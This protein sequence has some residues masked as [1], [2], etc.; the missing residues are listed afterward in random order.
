MPRK[1][2]TRLHDM[3]PT[4]H[5]YAELEMIE[6]R[7][8]VLWGVNHYMDGGSRVDINSRHAITFAIMTNCTV[9]KP[10]RVAFTLKQRGQKKLIMISAPH[11]VPLEKPRN[12]DGTMH[13]FVLSLPLKTGIPAVPFTVV[14]GGYDIEASLV[15]QQGDDLG[16]GAVVSG[17]TV[18][19]Y[20]PT[21]HFV[22][23]TLFYGATPPPAPAP[24]TPPRPIIGITQALRAESAS[25]IPDYYPIAPFSLPTVRER[26]WLVSW[27]AIKN[28]D[29]WDA[30]RYVTGYVLSGFDQTQADIFA[31][32]PV[33][34]RFMTA[35]SNAQ[36]FAAF[37]NGANRMVIVMGQYDYD[38][39]MGSS[40]IASYNL[41]NKAVLMRSGV[42]AD[43]V[44]HEVAHTLPPP[45]WNPDPTCNFPYHNSGITGVVADP[46]GAGTTANGYAAGERLRLNGA[47]RRVFTD[48][49]L[50]L[51][52]GAV[53]V[54]TKRVYAYTTQCTYWHLTDAMLAPPD[55]PVFLVRGV[56]ARQGSRFAALL[57]P[58]YT[59]TGSADLK[60]DARG[61][62]RITLLDASGKTLGSYAFTPD[63]NDENGKPRN[64]VPF[65]YR[66]PQLPGANAIVLEGEGRRIV[67]R[68]SSAAPAVRILA[69]RGTV[70]VHA[71]GALDVRW[72]AS[73]QKGYAA[74]S[75]V[76]VSDD[77]GKTYQAQVIESSG[78]RATVYVDP[79]Q[80]KHRI[81]VVVSDYS[82]SS[83]SNVDVTTSRR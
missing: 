29:W 81:K 80:R 36:G 48:G 63:W 27:Q 39:I 25:M 26:S 74:V 13:R 7:D 21:L 37:I 59:L 58:A 65:A 78:N 24:G 23:M 22:P 53:L 49:T 46:Y 42:N 60:S 83:E 32:L 16:L 75:S 56:L 70:R 34:E 52:G 61:S 47:R 2:L 44:A 11:M 4:A 9:N 14:E 69:P 67:L 15:S 5:F 33:V 51:M 10:V 71:N 19:T 8:T 38:T 6:G 43:T 66:V 1:Q 54:K 82:R 45:N 73:V 77:G 20:P 62:W 64:A 40:Q 41:G 31:N 79:N 17:D 12:A 50:H 30:T 18:I 3:D 35:I 55:P 57:G 76:F 72:Q 68:L 28:N